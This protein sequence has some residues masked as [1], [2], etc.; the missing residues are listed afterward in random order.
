MV[1]QLIRVRNVSGN[2]MVDLLPPKTSYPIYKLVREVVL[3][4]MIDYMSVP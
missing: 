2:E 3:S 4:E 1:S